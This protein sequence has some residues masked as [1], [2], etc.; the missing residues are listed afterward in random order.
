LFLLLG[1]GISGV[2][3][4]SHSPLTH[5]LLAPL[6][7]QWSLLTDLSG[8]I[9]ALVLQ[10]IPFKKRT[11]ASPV[12]DLKMASSNPIVAVLEDGIRDHIL[13]RMQRE[14]IG[15]SRR[16]DWNVIKSVAYRSVEEEIMVGRLKREE[17]DLA[18]KS[19]EA[20]QGSTNAQVYTRESDPGN[21][22]AQLKCCLGVLIFVLDSRYLR[23]C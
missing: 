20:L 17:A 3:M 7:A 2:P 4:T 23:S 15:A 16:Y 12:V 8:A 5:S 21:W 19:I 9:A 13:M 10:T 1:L 22:A 6:G 18:I 14:I 11:T